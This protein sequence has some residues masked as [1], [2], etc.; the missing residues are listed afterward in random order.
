VLRASWAAERWSQQAGESRTPDPGSNEDV[1]LALNVPV[2]VRG[3]HEAFAVGRGHRKGVEFRARR[4][5]L[6]PG[7]IEIDEI[8]I[9]VAR[10]W[11]LV[12]RGEDDALPVRMKERREAGAA[13]IRNPALVGSVSV[14]H[15]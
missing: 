14:H 1:G 3:P 5:L 7:A 15:P 9:E 10:A 6:E 4:D 13:E 2:A 12:V 11:V 8:Q